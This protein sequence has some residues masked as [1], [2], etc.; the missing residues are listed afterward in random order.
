MKLK[1]WKIH[2]RFHVSTT[3]VEVTLAVDSD[4]FQANET[5][6]ITIVVTRDD[7]LK[8]SLSELEAIAIERALKVTE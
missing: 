4:A 3:S 5:G 1:L 6:Q 2:Y 7:V 8:L